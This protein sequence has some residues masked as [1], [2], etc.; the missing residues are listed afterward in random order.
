M[1]ALLPPR[2]LGNSHM[3]ARLIRPKSAELG[4][5]RQGDDEGRIYARAETQT[6]APPGAANSRGRPGQTP[7]NN[8]TFTT[9]SPFARPPRA[10]SLLWAHELGRLEPRA[11]MDNNGTTHVRQTPNKTGA[12][13]IA[14]QTSSPLLVESRTWAHTRARAHARMSARTSTSV[15]GRTKYP[16]RDPGARAM[17]CFVITHSAPTSSSQNAQRKSKND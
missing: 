14:P 5:T 15:V 11:R 7:R 16:Q 10:P 1:R 13:S 3:S 4:G 8:P 6:V 17:R 12:L 9:G 2:P